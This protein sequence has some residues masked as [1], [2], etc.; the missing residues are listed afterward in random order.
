MQIKNKFVENSVYFNIWEL[1][2]KQIFELENY[3]FLYIYME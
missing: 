2:L 1:I 3:I